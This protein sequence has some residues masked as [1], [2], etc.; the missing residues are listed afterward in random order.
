MCTHTVYT[1]ETDASITLVKCISPPIRDGSGGW[2][3]PTRFNVPIVTRWDGLD[4]EVVSDNSERDHAQS[5]L[6]LNSHCRW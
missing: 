3:G 4:G 5:A 1:I 6:P 2:G